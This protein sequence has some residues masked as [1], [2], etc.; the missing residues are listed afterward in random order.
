MLPRVRRFHGVDLVAHTSLV[1]V[2]E[3]LDGVVR[4]RV[5]AQSA[6]QHGAAIARTIDDGV[7]LLAGILVD[8]VIQSPDG[9]PHNDHHHHGNQVMV[10]NDRVSWVNI[11][12]KCCIYLSEN[13]AVSWRTG[14]LVVDVVI[15]SRQ[16]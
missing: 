1:I 8:F 13:L 12:H 4:S 5:L 9:E 10:N 16:S 14:V 7:F 11:Q 2:D 6:Q 3:S 15:K